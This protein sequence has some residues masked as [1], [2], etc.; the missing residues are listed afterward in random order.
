MG[1]GV[2]TGA[3]A[4]V[5]SHIGQ[6]AASCS[7]SNIELSGTS[8]DTES[9]QNSTTICPPSVLTVFVGNCLPEALEEPSYSTCRL[10]PHEDFIRNGSPVTASTHTSLVSVLLHIA[11]QFA[12]VVPTDS[13]FMLS[14]FS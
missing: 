10:S 9:S 14:T 4:L 1:S 5:F 6:T 13:I 8:R 7:G 3:G 11:T 2:K 12:V